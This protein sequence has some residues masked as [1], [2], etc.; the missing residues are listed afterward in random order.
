M[1]KLFSLVSIAVLALTVG[2]SEDQ[3]TDQPISEQGTLRATTEESTRTALNGTNVVW[4][5]NDKLAVLTADAPATIEEYTLAS[6][7][8]VT[9][10]NFAG[11]PLTGS[12]DT[13]AFYPYNA[14]IGFAEGA[15][16][17]T[18]PATQKFITN[19][20]ANNALPMVSKNTSNNELMFKNLMGIVKLQIGGDQMVSSITVTT[21]GEKIAGTA[22]VA[23]DYT[24]APKL[25]M[26]ASG[27]T[28]ISLTEVNTT[29]T[30]APVAFYIALPAGDYAAG[31]KFELK[32]DQGAAIWSITTSKP[33]TV[34]RS[35]VAALAPA[36]TKNF[37]DAKF[38]AYLTKKY[39]LVLTAD[40]TDIDMNNAANIAQFLTITSISSWDFPSKPIT[41][42]KGIENFT[43]L[44]MF[45][46][47]G[48]QVTTLDLSKNTKLET[49]YCLGNRL[50]SL[51][52]SKNTKLINL[53]CFNNRMTTLDISANTLINNLGCGGQTTNGTTAQPLTL[54]CNA[55]QL[56]G[57]LGTGFNNT[58]VNKALK[59]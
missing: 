35:V 42:F 51:D 56:A 26:D 7:E 19:S 38:R 44:T 12:G 41:S 3:T 54:W 29:L 5:L 11:K 28:S 14:N 52:L 10:G 48:Q 58:N 36:Y 25:M 39:K 20:F 17:F 33:L 8:G 43:Q 55:T 16:N 32:D 1:K 21:A 30:A 49:L 45:T 23:M 9:T 24:D 53:L 4:S 40:G 31:M 47:E 50:T 13:Y 15:F 18:L 34:T 6:K 22:S 37:P 46:C 2:C 59:Q 57:N 27:T